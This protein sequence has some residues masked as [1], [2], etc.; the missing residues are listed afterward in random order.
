MNEMASGADQINA[1]VHNVNEMTDKNR[2]AIDT[3]L[4]EVSLF[5]VE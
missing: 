1:A 2:Q 5:K 4:K 3:L